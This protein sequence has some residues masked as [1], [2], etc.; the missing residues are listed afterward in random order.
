MCVSRYE[1]EVE[2]QLFY[3][4]FHYGNIRKLWKIEAHKI[5]Q[6]NKMPLNVDFHR[7]KYLDPKYSNEYEKVPDV[8]VTF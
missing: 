1:V 7:T 5:T 6:R 2:N 4:A 8:S 3:Q